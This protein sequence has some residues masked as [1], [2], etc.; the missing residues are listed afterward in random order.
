MANIGKQYSFV[1]RTLRF[2][3]KLIPK[4]LY[5]RGQPLYHYLLALF[6]AFFYRFPGGHIFVVAVTGTKGKTSTTEIIN[7]IL[8][9]AGHK[10]ALANT[11]RFK[12][13]D[14]SEPNLFKQSLR[15]R[16][17]VH[18]FLRMAVEADCSYAILE[19]TSEAARQS[20]HRFIDL[21]ALVFTNITPEHIESHGSFEKYLAAK[22][23]IRDQLER[24]KK[25]PKWVIA[26]K[27]SVHA[28]EFL[29]AHTASPLSFSLH[30]AEP[31]QL[32]ERGIDLTFENL[33]MH[34]PLFGRGNLEN[35]LAAATFSRTQGI[36]ATSIKSAVEK[37]SRIPGRG[38]EIIEGQRFRVIVDYAHTPESL[39][40]LYETY[41]T[42]RKL[43]VLGATGG[44]RDCWK[45]PVF[46][47]LVDRHCD[48][49]VLTDEDPYDEDPHA[50]VKDVASGIR[51]KQPHIEMDR[52]KAIRYAIHK[53]RQDDVVLIT[54]KG[55]D[56]YICGPH[57]TKKPWS[58]AE[59]TRQELQGY[60]RRTK[61]KSR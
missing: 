28:D 17:F 33:Y 13:G 7:V 48:E 49:I 51:Y 56:P 23:S 25:S 32:R 58:D 22:L 27:E 30:D 34:S 57:G 4:K 60:R 31:Y 15:G 36:D 3:E 59:V 35:I 18:R 6:A 61:S 9:E 50:I 46:G 5:L 42:Q 29:H 44:G 39:E 37:L 14:E 26:N 21:D 52:R 24:S 41:K 8:E 40:L 45:R 43:C 1:E 53:A 10:T 54:G 19:I 47:K 38:E 2:V 12:I 16:L 55:T 20:R 11:V